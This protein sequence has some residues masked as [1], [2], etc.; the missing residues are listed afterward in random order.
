[1]LLR[2]SRN[3][4][5]QIKD[6]KIKPD[7]AG[8]RVVFDEQRRGHAMPASESERQHG[9]ERKKYFHH[10]HDN[11]LAAQPSASCARQGQKSDKR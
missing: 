10:A 1:M 6:A 11:F 3:V 2:S 4:A 9:A 7:G 8:G 5:K